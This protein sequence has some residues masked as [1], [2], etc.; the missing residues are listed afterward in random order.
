MSSYTST[1]LRMSFIL[2]AGFAIG[3]FLVGL[4]G[5]APKTKVITEVVE[6]DPLPVQPNTDYYDGCVAGLSMFNY[7]HRCHHN[8]IDIIAVCKQLDASK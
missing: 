6:A 5:C 1:I 3:Y 4:T 2:I 7:K 8:V